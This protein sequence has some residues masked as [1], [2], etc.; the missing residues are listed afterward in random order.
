MVQEDS[1]EHTH[2]N[3]STTI[4]SSVFKGVETRLKHYRDVYGF[5]EATPRDNY[6]DDN[7]NKNNNDTT[8]IQK[9]HHENHCGSAPEYNEFFTLPSGERSSS[10]EDKLMYRFF[11]RDETPSVLSSS[12]SSVDNR[13][14]VE[15]GA[16]NG[17][18]EKEKIMNG[19]HVFY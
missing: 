9:I 14:Y 8:T 18:L 15:M 17:K 4:Q 3:N 10:N 5:E 19:Q 16:F 7:N 12:P 11:F 6:N 13:I 1:R 2:S